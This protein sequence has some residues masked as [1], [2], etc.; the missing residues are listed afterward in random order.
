MG[1]YFL[2]QVRT[3]QPDNGKPGFSLSIGGPVQSAALRICIHQHDPPSSPRERGG[4][5]NS[6]RGLS[7]TTF[8]VQ[9]GEDHSCRLCGNTTLRFSVDTILRASSTLAYGTQR[10]SVKIPG[11]GGERVHN[12]F[13]S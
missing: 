6:E 12:P 9:E 5:V 11:A 3:G 8:L 10:G 7:D 4:D 13:M 1:R 2:V